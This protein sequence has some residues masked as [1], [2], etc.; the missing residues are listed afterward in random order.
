MNKFYALLFILF[1]AFVLP[2]C[3]ALPSILN[4]VDHAVTDSDVALQ[5]IE[6]AFNVYQADHPV[7]PADRA[8]FEKLM[9][10]A[11]GTLKT[12]AQLEHDAKDVSQGNFDQ[13]FADFK[14]AFAAIK[15]F[16]KQ[17][18]ISPIGEGLVGASQADTDGFPVPLVIG[19][20]LQS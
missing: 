18:G 3:A 12:G 19:L 6:T 8:T 2:N 16:M 14:V 9:A 1:G 13:A 10:T 17:K 15:D 5:I 7:S 20:R 4:T 11:Y